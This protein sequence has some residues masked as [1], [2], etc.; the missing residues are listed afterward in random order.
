MSQSLEAQIDGL[1]SL[2]RRG[3]ERRWR[4]LFKVTP[5]ASYTPDLLARGIAHHLQE[6]AFGRLAPALRRQLERAV[7]VNPTS[8]KGM[9]VGNRL[10]RRWRGRTYVV[11]AVEGGFSYDGATFSSLSEIARLITGTRW[12]GPR[13]FGLVQ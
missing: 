12:S 11:D 9:R 10:V 13:F 1:P 7:E 5:P 8:N 2:G 3:L 6:K 4:E